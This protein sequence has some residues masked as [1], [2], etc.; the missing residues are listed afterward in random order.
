MSDTHHPIEHTLTVV[1]NGKVTAEPDIA[2]ILFQ[3]GGE[4]FDAL[5]KARTDAATRMLRCIAA[6]TAA[7]IA[8]RDRRTGAFVAGPELEWRKGRQETVG[9]AVRSVIRVTVRDL[10]AAGEL[11]DAVMAAG[12]SSLSGPSFEVEDDAAIRIAAQTAAV[13]DARAGAD[14]Q[15]AALGITITGVASVSPADGGGFAPQP[16]YRMAAMAMDA[17]AAPETPIEAG[18]V[19]VTA[20]VQVTFLIT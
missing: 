15:A 17:G 6:L 4:R 12:A 11:I 1:G 3:V 16:I 14:A 7:G 8:D 18:T 20:S 10:S 19:D 13:R 5:A 2:R 9:Y